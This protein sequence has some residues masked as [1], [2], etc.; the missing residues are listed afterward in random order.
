[1]KPIRILL[2]DDHNLVR[3]GFRSLLESLA[4]VSIVS[5]ACNG[6]EA[7]QLIE[8]QHPDVVLMDIG[9]PEL[10]GLEAT[11][12]ATQ[13][14]PAVRV[15][16]LSMHAD[17]EY[18]LKALRAGAA[19]YLLKDAD[20]TQLE[21]A[22]RAVANGGTFLSPS[23]SKQ[24]ID[25]YLQRVGSESSGPQE[26]TPRQ[27]ELLQLIAEGRTKQEIAQLLNISLKTVETHRDQMME[28]LGIHDVAGLVRYAIRT[29]IVSADQ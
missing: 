2:A 1:M 8:T 16:I 26:L 14:Y 7:L 20:I 13:D 4:G 27:R 23:I 12:R 10:N 17:K 25:D 11:T 18:V 6:R 5:E 28:R 24:V 22:V 29:G 21:L 19:G 15:I 3:A 9:M